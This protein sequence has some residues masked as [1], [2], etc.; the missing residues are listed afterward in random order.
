MF[1]V[2][3]SSDNW[4]AASKYVATPCVEYVTKLILQPST[5]Q[6]NPLHLKMVF[7]FCGSFS[8]SR[9]DQADDRVCVYMYITD[10]LLCWQY[11]I[12]ILQVWYTCVNRKDNYDVSRS[13]TRNNRRV[14]PGSAPHGPCQ[15]DDRVCVYMYITDTLLCWQYHIYKLQFD[16]PV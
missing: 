4:F 3:E 15:A 14:L 12:Y 6:R 5:R 7:F 8:K 10:T 13:K 2:L 1:H 16:L 9:T 11:H